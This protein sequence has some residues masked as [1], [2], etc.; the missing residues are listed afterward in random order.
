MKKVCLNYKH[1]KKQKDE[2]QKNTIP[3]MLENTAML[4]RV[5]KVQTQIDRKQLKNMYN[6]KYR[7]GGR[8]NEYRGKII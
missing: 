6:F 5:A 7:K 8:N 2:N 3:E 1:K 4:I